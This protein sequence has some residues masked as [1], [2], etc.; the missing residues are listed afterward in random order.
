MDISGNLIINKPI[1][2]KN[3]ID[4][5]NFPIIYSELP[6]LTKSFKFYTISGEP[7]TLTYTPPNYHPLILQHT[8]KNYEKQDPTNY[9]YLKYFNYKVN[10][11]TTDIS[12]A[13][14]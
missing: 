10:L 5:G 8:I 11:G 7:Y 9:I 3:G 14:I 4:Y 12:I 13:G 1:I 6:S 2:S